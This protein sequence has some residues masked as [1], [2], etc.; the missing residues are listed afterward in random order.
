MKT[1]SSFGS[2]KK[3]APFNATAR[4]PRA[5][6]WMSRDA[7]GVVLN[8]NAAPAHGLNGLSGLSVGPSIQ[9]P[10]PSEPVTV[11]EKVNVPVLPP[12]ERPKTL[13]GLAL[14]SSRSDSSLLKR[15]RTCDNGTAHMRGLRSLLVSSSSASLLPGS[16]I[17]KEVE[18]ALTAAAQNG[19]KPED[20]LRNARILT[21]KMKEYNTIDSC[22][23][24]L[25]GT[26]P[27][28]N[29]VKALT[30]ARQREDCWQSEIERQQN[31]AKA[32]EFLAEL[33]RGPLFPEFHIK[34][35]RGCMAT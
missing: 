19:V 35:N 33:S 15:P 2:K 4:K 28:K 24:L 29:G 22:W 7:L 14:Q 16:S 25:D 11:K 32:P 34:K 5:A 6:S 3:A 31:L 26:R 10:S 17:Q 1:R 9:L 12:S 21:R 20:Q 23:Q 30:T 13:G 27:L 18:N 8:A